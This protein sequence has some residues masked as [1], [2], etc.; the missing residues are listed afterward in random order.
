MAPIDPLHGV[1][2]ALA[3]AVCLQGT[4]L[5]TDPRHRRRLGQPRRAGG[6]RAVRQAL[7]DARRRPIAAAGARPLASPPRPGVHPNGLQGWGR[8]HHGGAHAS[9]QR[10]RPRR[11]PQAGG[12]PGARLPS[13]SDADGLQGR[14]EP[15]RVPRLRVDEAGQ[16]LREEATDACGS[17]AHDLPPPQLAT[18]GQGPP[19]QVR[20]VALIPAMPRGRG[21]GTP[22]T[23]RARG[24][25]R[26]LELKRLRRHGDGIDMH[27]ARGRE[28]D[29]E[30][31][32]RCSN[33]LS[34]HISYM[35]LRHHTGSPD[36]P[37]VPMTPFF[38]SPRAS[39]RPAGASGSAHAWRPGR[40]RCTWHS[41]PSVK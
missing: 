16:A 34:V 2:P 26:E 27:G 36:S 14:D 4:P 37:K 32:G 29:R 17:E 35:D 13:Q 33:C 23:A 20:Q 6:S 30:S 10:G 19:R 28:E 39:R 9:Q 24:G 40:S 12:E 15:T 25:R 5:P 38:Y 21:R 11:P 31:C 3:H 8:G 1:G 18:Y 41:H 7:D 22:R